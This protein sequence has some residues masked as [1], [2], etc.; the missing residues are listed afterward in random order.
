M[1]GIDAILMDIHMPILNGMEAL[2]QVRKE[3]KATTHHTPIIALTADAL[4]VT[5]E[6]LL[7]A[8]FDGYLTKPVKVR[9]L[10]DELVRVT[11]V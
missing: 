7:A 2:E 11:A 5:E 3:E 1:G 9:G 10:A 4:K 8:G 6:M